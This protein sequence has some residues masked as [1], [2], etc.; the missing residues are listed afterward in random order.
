MLLHVVVILTRT[1]LLPQAA[2][3]GKDLQA[4]FFVQFLSK[5]DGMLTL[6]SMQPRLQTKLPMPF[7]GTPQVQIIF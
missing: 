6:R 1:C 7:S 3:S 2:E 5:E 4:Q